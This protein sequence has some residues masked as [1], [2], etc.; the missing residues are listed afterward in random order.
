LHS[1]S[2]PQSWP[3]DLLGDVPISFCPQTLELVAFK[4]PFGQLDI[5]HVSVPRHVS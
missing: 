4:H 3:M 2:P 1:L 5:D